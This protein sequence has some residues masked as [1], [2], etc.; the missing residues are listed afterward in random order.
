MTRGAPKTL[1]SADLDQVADLLR[2][3][4]SFPQVATDLGLSR[5]QV[6]YRVEVMRQ[7]LARSTGDV[8]WLDA[9]PVAVSRGWFAEI[10]PA[11]LKRPIKALAGRPRE[12]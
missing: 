7:D 10:V 2:Q 12:S 8:G 11:D 4:V 1:N 6:Q 9:N 3:G 5:R